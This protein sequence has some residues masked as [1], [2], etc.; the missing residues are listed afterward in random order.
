MGCG[1]GVCFGCTLRYREDDGRVGYRLCCADGCLFPL[2]RLVLE[3]PEGGAPQRPGVEASH[4][5][6]TGEKGK[7][8]AQEGSP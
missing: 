2:D 7:T 5:T 4:V 6:Q 8:A 1:F 3:S